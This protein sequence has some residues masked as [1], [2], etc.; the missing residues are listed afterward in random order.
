[1][2]NTITE[3]LV[4]TLRKAS[5]E[6]QSPLWKRVAEDL[7]KPTRKRRIVNVFKLDAHT[8]DGD[9]VLVPGKVL[10]EGEL[11]KKLTVAAFAFSDEARMKIS[12]QGKAITIAELMKS[13][14]KGQKVKLL[15]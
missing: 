8:K 5:I 7:E 6:Q 13:H 11:T 12:K 10:G 15:G 9:V 1:M 4:Q 3:G 2:K 14:P